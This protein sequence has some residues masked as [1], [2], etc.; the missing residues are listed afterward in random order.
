MWPSK[1]L[2]PVIP[3]A[4]ALILAGCGGEEAA[5]PANPAAPAGAEAPQ[6]AAAAPS[7]PVELNVDF[8]SLARFPDLQFEAIGTIEGEGDPRVVLS[9]GAP[10]TNSTGQPAGPFWVAKPPAYFIVNMP[11]GKGGIQVDK[12]TIEDAG[13][14][15]SF[16]LCSVSITTADQPEWHPPVGLTNRKELVKNPEGDWVRTVIQFDEVRATGVRIALPAGNSKQPD[17]VFLRDID[18]IGKLGG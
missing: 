18:V 5:P 7:K 15:K 3:V 12:V 13:G 8:A 4:L 17:R 2:G 14:D 11:T 6:P 9:D 1:I 16:P 10:Q